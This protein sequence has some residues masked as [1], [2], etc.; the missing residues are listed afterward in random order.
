MNENPNEE[1]ESLVVNYV[2]APP[3]T[4][5][6]LAAI[7]Y[8]KN[9][10]Q[11]GLDGKRVG[12][13]FYVAPTVD[14][15]KQ[16]IENL[17]TSLPKE[18]HGM[19]RAVYS[20][21]H[22]YIKGQNTEE[23]VY[24]LLNGRVSE[25]FHGKPFTIGSILFVTHETFIRL[26]RH[27]KFE[28]TTVIFDESRKW[29]D[30]VKKVPMDDESEELFNGLF[31]MTHLKVGKEVHRGINVLA[32][33]QLADNQKAKLLQSKSSA[34]SFVVLDD[35]HKHLQPKEGEPIRMRTY[36]MMEGSKRSNGRDTRRMIQISLPSH[37]FVGF[38]SIYVLSADFK[39][40]QMYHLM[41][42]EGVLLNDVTRT[43]MDKYTKGGYLKALDAL[44]TRYS[45]VKIVPLLADKRVPAKT[46]LATGVILPSKN[47]VRFYKMMEKLNI[48]TG[49][50]QSM[51]DSIRNPEASH[52]GLKEH[53]DKLLAWMNKNDVH[54][55]ILRWQLDSAQHIAKKWSDRY[56]RPRPG[57]LFVNKDYESYP[58]DRKV[59]EQLSI[60]RAEGRNDF[61]EANVV[62]FLAAVN[63]QPVLARLLN[64]LL[65]NQGY[66]SDEDYVVDKAVQCIG[67]GNVRDHKCKSPML[68]IVATRG[69]AYRLK[70]RMN[71]SPDISET[72]LEKTGHYVT[73]SY[74]AFK[75]QRSKEENNGRTNEEIRTKRY[76]NNPINK[77][78]TSLRTLRSRYKK[79]LKT[80]SAMETK[81]LTKKLKDVEEKIAILTEQRTAAK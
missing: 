14:L 43:F 40:S 68:A 17:K 50:L 67:R 36:A 53:H 31:T 20:R 29:A 3:G 30:M 39:T 45:N 7:Q 8:M 66:D 32:A 26:R 37:P 9:H 48:N 2:S 78:L 1:V 4:G 21:E 24:D 41:K 22:L 18:Q 44:H 70:D 73:W 61:M 12:Y 56:G 11:R 33:K 49:E 81:G 76:L 38:K 58:I 27:D 59:F 75:E 77:K 52:I 19:V 71:G 5:K 72:W 6:T 54:L 63:P 51:V 69:L 80:A 15:L 28:H 47:L 55:D 60:G 16:T 25:K 46:K 62:C 74:N 13:I 79:A 10:I 42:M 64:A 35:L 65:S 34:K 57:V 23:Q